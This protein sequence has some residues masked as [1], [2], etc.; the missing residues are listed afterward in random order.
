L[1]GGIGFVMQRETQTPLG[2]KLPRNAHTYVR[3]DCFPLCN[4]PT[5]S[6][7]EEIL[8]S[9]DADDDE[10]LCFTDPRTPRVK[11]LSELSTPQ[12]GSHV[13]LRQSAGF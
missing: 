8:R 10:F 5:A 9:T 7:P 12:P 3:F 4:L 6:R 1:T 13:W 2:V 11:K